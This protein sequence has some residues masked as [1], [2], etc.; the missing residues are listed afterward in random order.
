LSA[1]AIPQGKLDEPRRS[2]QKGTFDHLMTLHT[3]IAAIPKLLGSNVREKGQVD[4]LGSGVRE[5]GKGL[6]YGWWDGITGLAT[7]PW[8][9]AQKEVRFWG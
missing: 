6:F 5:A 3:G 7:E 1:T 2:L 8:Q 9:G 4:D